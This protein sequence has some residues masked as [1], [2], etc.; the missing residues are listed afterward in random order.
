MGNVKL[1]PAIYVRNTK[2]AAYADMIVKGEKTIETRTRDVLGRFVS[3]R[4]LII[5]TGS[6]SPTIIGSVIIKSKKFCS[7][8]EMNSLRNE[9]KIPAGS[10]FDCHN[11][12]KWCYE[13]SDP[14]E[15]RTGL[16]LADFSVNKRTRSWAMIHCAY[17]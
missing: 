13:L 10:K 3:H 1:F 9:T 14:V 4:V 8:D 12:G 6:Y 2:E 16:F 7:A 5:R 17:L 15:W 11:A